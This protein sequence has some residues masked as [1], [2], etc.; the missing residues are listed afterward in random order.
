MRSFTHTGIGQ[1]TSV[2]GVGTG[3]VYLKLL[4]KATSENLL[5][6]NLLRHRRTT[7]ISKADK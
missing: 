2:T 3:G 7:D 6:E 4:A 1:L 5:T